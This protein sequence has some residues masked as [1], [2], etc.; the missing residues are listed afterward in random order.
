MAQLSSA[1][2]RTIVI[3]SAVAAAAGAVASA[4]V[5]ALITHWSESR[6]AKRNEQA[7]VDTAAMTVEEMLGPQPPLSGDHPYR[8]LARRR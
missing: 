7:A 5:S 1:D 4:V 6:A 3:T 2:L 8:I